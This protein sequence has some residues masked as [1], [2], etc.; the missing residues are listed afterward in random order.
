MVHLIKWLI[1]P[2]TLAQLHQVVMGLEHLQFILDFNLLEL[3]LH[4]IHQESIEEIKFLNLLQ[5]RKFVLLLKFVTLKV[6]NLP[7]QH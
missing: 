4:Q 1:Q 5:R 2:I 7:L 6:V 3:E